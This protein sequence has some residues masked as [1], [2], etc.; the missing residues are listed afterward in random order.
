[1]FSPYWRK[2]LSPLKKHSDTSLRSCF[3]LPKSKDTFSSEYFP[4]FHSNP[5]ST[6]KG[7]TCLMSSFIWSTGNLC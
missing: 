1:M 4:F 5:V 7:K 6:T 3:G 2:M